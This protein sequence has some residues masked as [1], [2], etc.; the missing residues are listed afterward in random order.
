MHI[1]N[2]NINKSSQQYSIN[3]DKHITKALKPYLS[4]GDTS[5]KRLFSSVLKYLTKSYGEE[6]VTKLVKLIEDVTVKT[7]SI[8]CP[9]LKLHFNATFGRLGGPHCNR[10][11]F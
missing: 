2:S 5:H 3:S 1:T 6:T 11:C 9:H 10:N 4:G 7:A 8:I